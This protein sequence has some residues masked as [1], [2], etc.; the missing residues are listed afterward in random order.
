MSHKISQ[1]DRVKCVSQTT[2]TTTQTSLIWLTGR[3]CSNGEQ[4]SRRVM[5]DCY[6]SGSCKWQLQLSLQ[7]QNNMLGGHFGSVYL[8]VII[9]HSNEN[10]VCH[11]Y[12]YCSLTL[13]WNAC[14]DTYVS[15]VLVTVLLGKPVI[16]TMSVCVDMPSSNC[17]LNSSGLLTDF[18]GCGRRSGLYR[19]WRRSCSG[20]RYS[21]QLEQN[22][23][24]YEEKNKCA[25]TT[26]EQHTVL[27]C[28][29]RQCN[30][31]ASSGIQAW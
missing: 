5:T 26:D 11:T 31:L 23:D 29:L 21:C 25:R 30:V 20:S 18:W 17:D 15:L 10:T 14:L 27:R 22:T 6:P 13:F 19:W 3:K 1:S 24:F 2:T 9:N 12:R 28:I 4:S 8:L 7:I 16:K